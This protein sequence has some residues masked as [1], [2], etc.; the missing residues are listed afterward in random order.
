MA[1]PWAQEI[2][3]HLSR[4]LNDDS[5]AVSDDLFSCDPT[6]LGKLKKSVKE[7]ASSGRNALPEACSNLDDLVTNAYTQL[8]TSK[9]SP[10]KWRRLYTDASIVRS[11]ADIPQ[12]NDANEES[13]LKSIERLDRAIVIAGPCGEGRLDL[14]LYLITKIQ[15][16]CLQSMFQS[17][18][19]D[20]N[21][22][23][24]V[25]DD[26]QLPKT[27]SKQIIRLHQPPSFTSF[28]DNY[29]KQPFAISGFAKDW[30]AMNEHPWDSSNYLRSVSGPGRVIPV[31]IGSDYR[32][33]DWSQTM[34][35]FDDFLSSIISNESITP[36]S[37]KPILYLAQHNLF[38]QFPQ[39]RE[40]IIVPDYVYSSLSPPD[41]YPEY[42]PP[43]NE[44]QLVINA[45]IGPKGTNSPAHTD[46]FYNFYAQIVGRKTVWLAPPSVSPYMYPYPP[47]SSPS[48]SP[49]DTSNQP[50][51]SNNEPK[52]QQ[53]QPHNP[54]SNNTSPNMSNTSQ[55]DVFAS[56]ETTQ[57]G[58]PNFWNHVIPEAICVT[59][60]PGDLLFFPPGWWHA[61]RSEDT[62]FSVSMWF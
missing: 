61:M 38:T 58:F 48:P 24:K 52:P 2:L 13:A 55:L 8:S 60:N 18:L 17:N 41:D 10:Y 47:P 6:I 44:E 23:G 40:D 19:P 45:W 51:D 20:H 26:P 50:S 22:A 42:K 11:L 5:Y 62:S 27:F 3:L 39:L 7:I 4:Q 36:N 33:D 46:P 32:E 49:S 31:E 9:Y 35:N 30:P 57:P 37:K 59:L 34:M 25:N 53:Q 12:L 1:H 14:I 28:L 15:K 29:S 43:S 56:S 16:E 54:A 21:L